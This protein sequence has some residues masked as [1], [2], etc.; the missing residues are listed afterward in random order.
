MLVKGALDCKGHPVKDSMSHRKCATFCCA[1]FSCGFII[2]YSWNQVIYLPIYPSGLHACTCFLDVLHISHPQQHTTVTLT[3][4]K[5][6]S[7]WQL[8]RQWWHRKLSLWQLMVP[9]VT[10]KLST[11][12]FFVFREWYTYKWQMKGILE[13]IKCWKSIAN[14]LSDDTQMNSWIKCINSYFSFIR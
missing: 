12:W 3:E 6:W 4:E 5:I 8:C 11:W 9:P 1:L 14:K 13:K 10:T 2:Y 7:I